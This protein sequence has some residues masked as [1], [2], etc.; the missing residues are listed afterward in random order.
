MP[1]ILLAALIVW[2][3]MAACSPPTFE[4]GEWQ[5]PGGSASAKSMPVEVECADF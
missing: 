3:A 5:P 2:A 4:H 1:R